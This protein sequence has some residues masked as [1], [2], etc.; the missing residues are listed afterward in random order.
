MHGVSQKM[1]AAQQ[2]STPPPNGEA[3]PHE[4]EK[5]HDENTVEGEFKEV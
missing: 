3:P 2:A 1:Y 5:P 4:G